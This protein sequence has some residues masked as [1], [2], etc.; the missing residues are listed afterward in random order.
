MRMRRTFLAV[1]FGAGA[2]TA[3][4]QRQ[5]PNS[6]KCPVC[7]AVVPEAPVNIQI[8]GAD[9]DM[10]GSSLTYPA[11]VCPACGVMFCVQPAAVANG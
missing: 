6:P 5:Q 7:K 4:I 10:D 3:Q 2:A 8:L 1:L 11:L 9:G